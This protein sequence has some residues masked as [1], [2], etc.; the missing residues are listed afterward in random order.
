[1]IRHYGSYFSKLRFL[2]GF[3]QCVNLSLPL[4]VIRYGDVI[5]LTPLPYVEA[6]TPA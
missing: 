3:S 5:F 2:F 6:A 1:M 4:V